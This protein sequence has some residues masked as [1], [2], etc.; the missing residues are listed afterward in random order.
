MISAWLQPRHLRVAFE[1]RLAYPNLL[2]PERFAYTITS[3]ASITWA[4][5]SDANK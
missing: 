3:A 1:P 2:K 5:L 4:H